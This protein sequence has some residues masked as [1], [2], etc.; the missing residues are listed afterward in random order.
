MNNTLASVLVAAVLVLAGVVALHSPVVNVNPQ[1]EVP[2]VEQTYGS[3]G[4]NFNF[5][6]VAQA[7][8]TV[9]GN[10]LASTTVA[11]ETLSVNDVTNNKLINAKA[12][13]ATTMT[14]PTKANLD[15]A[16]FIPNAGDTTSI[17]IHASTSVITLAGSTGVKLWTTA[18]T[19]QIFPLGTAELRFVRLGATEGKTIEV[20]MVNQF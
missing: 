2:S 18:S 11:T 20:Q 4:P 3:A 7:G 15:K 6:L 19:S 9:G 13:A 16:L 14:L 8:L 17:W 12:S 1:V 10:L 5:P